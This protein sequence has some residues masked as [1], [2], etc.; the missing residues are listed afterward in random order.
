MSGMSLKRDKKAAK[1]IDEQELERFGSQAG[2]LKAAQEAARV[3]TRRYKAIN[4]TISISTEE[5]ALLKELLKRSVTL[6]EDFPNKSTVF[7]AALLHL[8]RQDDEVLEALLD[9]VPNLRLKG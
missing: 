1:R 7:R 9:E 5:D 4:R 6:S 3:R 8:S 2:S